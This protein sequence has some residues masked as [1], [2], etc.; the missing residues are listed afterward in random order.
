MP[1]FC[2]CPLGIHQP[3]CPLS[4]SGSYTTLPGANFITT[5]PNYIPKPERTSWQCHRCHKVNAPHMNQCSCPGYDT[6]WSP[7]YVKGEPL[8]YEIIITPS[9]APDNGDDV[10]IFTT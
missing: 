4:N 2:L 9:V 3:G 7:F 1:L 5:D 6:T 10:T 8:P